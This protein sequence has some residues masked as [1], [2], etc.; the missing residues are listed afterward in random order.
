M[1]HHSDVSRILQGF[2]DIW[3]AKGV[4]GQCFYKNNKTGLVAHIPVSGQSSHTKT[5]SRVTPCF[6]GVNVWKR[7]THGRKIMYLNK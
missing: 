3:K 2:I 1:D 7:G 6:K 5:K 4:C